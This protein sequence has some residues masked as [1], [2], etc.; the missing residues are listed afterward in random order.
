MIDKN[1]SKQFGIGFGMKYF[2]VS[3]IELQHHS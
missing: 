1:I 2:L 3:I